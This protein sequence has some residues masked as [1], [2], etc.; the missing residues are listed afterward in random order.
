[1]YALTCKYKNLMVDLEVHIEHL[2]ACKH[3]IEV[4]VVD[5][6]NVD[7]GL[8]CSYKLIKYLDRTIKDSETIKREVNRALDNLSL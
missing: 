8:L 4:S 2:S 7:T 1:M 3:H 5:A 6:Y